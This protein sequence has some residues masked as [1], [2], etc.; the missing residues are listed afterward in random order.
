[1]ATRDQARRRILEAARKLFL[2]R[3]FEAANLDEVAQRAGVAK[4]TIYRYFDSKAELYVEVLVWNADAFVERMR[5]TLDP[6]LS[7]REQV[8]QTGRFYVRHY[9]EHPEYFRIFWAVENQRMIGELPEPL[10]EI[11]WDLWRRGLAIAVE[12]I[13]NG[14]K[15]GAFRPCDAWQ[16]ASL[17]WVLANGL[18][19]S[20]SDPHRRALRHSTLEEQIDDAFS[21]VVRGL[22]A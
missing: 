8:M 11:V 3:G 16:T 20:E 19:Q 15:V 9:A 4:G 10:L 17:L 6:S 7:P 14:V 2:E 21:L 5:H 12:I 13:E 22:S 18:I 1:M